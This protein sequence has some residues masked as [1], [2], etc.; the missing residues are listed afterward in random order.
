MI[1]DGNEKEGE[2]ETIEE[3]S[4]EENDEEGS[5]ERREEE[6]KEG[7]RVDREVKNISKVKKYQSGADLLRGEAKEI[8]ISLLKYNPLQVAYLFGLERHYSSDASMRS[9]IYKSYIWV[10]DD[11]EKYDIS[12]EMA[13][14]VEKCV[15]A[16][17]IGP[18][19]IKALK[20]REKDEMDKVTTSELI[21][22]GTDRSLVL[23]HR[24]FDELERH[25]GL[26][27]VKITDL[28][29]V[30]TAMF[31]KAQITRGEAT[32]NIAILSRHITKDLDV[33]LALEQIITSRENIA[34]QKEA[35]KNTRK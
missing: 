17:T 9:A 16:R 12:M 28:V 26:K 20:K 4:Y 6:G 30:V 3:E 11:P 22:K 35:Q 24:K 25:G 2:E 7:K 10:L 31:D 21:T 5:K 29:K 27:N 34:V 32:Q 14:A 33:E 13:A 23:L 15:K 1:Q 8:F 18:S 19:K